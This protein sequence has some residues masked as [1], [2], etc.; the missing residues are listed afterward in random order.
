LASAFSCRFRGKVLSAIASSILPIYLLRET[1][2]CLSSV[3]Q[4]AHF[5]RLISRARISAKLKFEA[6]SK[7]LQNKNL[8]N[9]EGVNETDF[10]GFLIF[11]L[12][13]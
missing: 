11:A 12:S 2:E 6:L 8:K 10:R 4:S 7:Q 3:F 9:T 13:V 1:L 5:R